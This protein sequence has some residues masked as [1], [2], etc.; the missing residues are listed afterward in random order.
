MT[1]SFIPGFALFYL[2]QFIMFGEDGYKYSLLLKSF[3]VIGCFLLNWQYD[4]KESDSK[5]GF[6]AT[7]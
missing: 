3:G 2:G 7:M 4:Q 1:A 6:V 5:Y